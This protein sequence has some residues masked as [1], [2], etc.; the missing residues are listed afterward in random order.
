MVAAAAKLGISAKSSAAASASSRGYAT[1]SAP[2]GSS[3]GG[4]SSQDVY[5]SVDTFIGEEAWFAELSKKY[6]MKVTPRERKVAGQQKRVISS[7]NN[8]WDVK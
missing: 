5:I 4:V 7:Y 1:Y 3:G 6:N 8:R 2:S